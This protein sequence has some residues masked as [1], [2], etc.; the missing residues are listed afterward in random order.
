[1]VPYGPYAGRPQSEQITFAANKFGKR[2][3]IRFGIWNATGAATEDPPHSGIWVYAKENAP[4][5]ALLGLNGEPL[6]MDT[7]QNLYLNMKAAVNLMREHGAV[8]EG[9][10]G[11]WMKAGSEAA[12][13]AKA[14]QPDPAV[15]AAA[16]AQR[17]KE[18][19]VEMAKRAARWEKLQEAQRESGKKEL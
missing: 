9:Q 17:K 2:A 15:V 7:E 16:A 5:A 12:A 4:G 11:R 3:G 14:Q 1:L 10:D 13:K 18:L 6:L 8:H 19:D